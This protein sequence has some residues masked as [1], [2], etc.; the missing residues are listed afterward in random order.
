MFKQS[1]PV[2]L[3]CGDSLKEVEDTQV[4]GCEHGLEMA[5]C[6][7]RCPASLLDFKQVTRGQD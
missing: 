1:L 3:G 4:V 7:W 6:T 2:G 5:L